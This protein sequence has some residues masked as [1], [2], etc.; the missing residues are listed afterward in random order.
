MTAAVAEIT[1]SE[2]LRVLMIAATPGSTIELNVS[3]AEALLAEVRH[4]RRDA[5]RVASEKFAR[6]AD[7][8]AGRYGDALFRAAE[9]ERI[10][11]GWTGLLVAVAVAGAAWGQIA[12][13]AAAIVEVLP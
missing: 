11:Q 10:A 13:I 12:Q 1:P 7:Q 4:L 6:L 5:D 8:F 2:R 9:A 3:A